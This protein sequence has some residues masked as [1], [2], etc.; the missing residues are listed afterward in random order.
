LSAILEARDVSFGIGQ[1][2]LVRSCTLSLVP[3]QLTVIVGPNGAGKSTLLKLISGELTPSAGAIT[4]FGQPLAG[5]PA[6]RLACRRAVMAQ[7]ARLNF[8]FAAHE[9]VHLGIEGLGRAR[10]SHLSEHLVAQAM[11]QADILHL[12]GRDYQTLS[13][14]EQQ[15]VQFARALCQLEAGQ[16]MEPRQA[17]L[18][19]EPI[20]S[21]DLC[22]QLTLLE[23]IRAL[24]QSRG[25][26]VLAILHDLN[27]A[28]HFA[29]ELVVMDGGEIVARG[30]PATVLDEACLLRVFG[31]KLS[32]PASVPAE[33][34]PAV[35]PRFCAVRRD[36][37]SM[38]AA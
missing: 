29:D 10:A 20:A 22:H 16:S 18:L 35:L 9:V 17:L 15:R 27:L 11:A 38:R 3:G 33:I 1:S 37:A 25:I 28:A 24:A 36:H 23:T 4:S 8:P 32:Y 7:I 19:D 14:G 26:A 6:W 34:K 12:A 30:A 2:V 5:V 13:G 31:V 21:L